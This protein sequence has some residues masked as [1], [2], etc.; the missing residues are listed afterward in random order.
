VRARSLVA[1]AL[2]LGVSLLALTPRPALAQQ[3]TLAACPANATVAVTQQSAGSS[4]VVV[5]V[6]P[7]VPIKAAADAD[8]QSF[9]VHYYVDTPT[10]TLEAGDVIPSGNPQIVHSGATTL[11]LKLAAGS[12]TVTVVLGQLG[13]QACG[14]NTG[15]LTAGT[16]TF[17]V[18]AQ[19]A[20]TATVAAPKTGNAGLAAT[21]GSTGTTA[22]AI[23]LGVLALS[24]AAAARRRA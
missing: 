5:S 4:T 21:A 7:A 16:A 14:D 1:G 13:H 22:L 2:L 8:P 17:T 11:D 23:T 20:P 3:P 18:A 6:V 10:D 9:H 24:G 12:H 19:A 15:K